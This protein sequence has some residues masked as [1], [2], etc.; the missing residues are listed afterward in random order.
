MRILA[1]RCAELGHL[2]MLKHLFQ[3]AG[4]CKDVCMEAKW[5]KAIADSGGVGNSPLMIAAWSGLVDTARPS[6]GCLQQ[7]SALDD[8]VWWIL[9]ATLRYR[10]ASE[11][12]DEG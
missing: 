1:V 9:L 11:P 12:R 7:K 8:R 2:D 10:G 4:V 6:A 3:E 5:L